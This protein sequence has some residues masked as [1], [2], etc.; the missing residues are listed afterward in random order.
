LAGCAARKVSAGAD[1]TAAG[2]IE[3]H[4][5]AAEKL[6]RG[7]IRVKR[8]LQRGDGAVTIFQR[9]EA[10]GAEIEAATVIER[11]ADSD[12]CTVL[13]GQAALHTVRLPT[14]IGYDR[15]NRIQ[16]LHGSLR[17]LVSVVPASDS[18]LPIATAG[19]FPTGLVGIPT[20]EPD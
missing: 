1:D 5:V 16:A 6:L 15:A 17:G 14:S 4:P 11:R 19:T 12:L 9:C 10:L 2:L 8:R 13:R 3:C 18:I 7:P 20:F